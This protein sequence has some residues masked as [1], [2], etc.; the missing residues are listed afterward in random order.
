[1][2]THERYVRASSSYNDFSWNNCNSLIII[3]MNSHQIH[4][5]VASPWQIYI[6]MYVH[7]LMHVRT[8]MICQLRIVWK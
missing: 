7:F 6:G 8:Y 1:M 4:F 3:R 2:H 5:N